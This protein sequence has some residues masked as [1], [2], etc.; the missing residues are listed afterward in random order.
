MRDHSFIDQGMAEI[1]YNH[2]YTLIQNFALKK[3]KKRETIYSNF[4][5]IDYSIERSNA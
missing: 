5:A 3:K 4:L 1:G 2:L